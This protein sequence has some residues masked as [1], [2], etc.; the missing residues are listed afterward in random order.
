[1]NDACSFEFCVIVLYITEILEGPIQV[2]FKY[3]MMARLFIQCSHKLKVM[4]N[5]N[6]TMVFHKGKSFITTGT[7]TTKTCL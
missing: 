6:T 2:E 7:C 1:M 5:P 4:L 3:S